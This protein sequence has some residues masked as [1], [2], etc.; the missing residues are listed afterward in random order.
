MR[1]LVGV[2]PYM[3]A[4]CL[5][6]KRHRLLQHCQFGTASVAGQARYLRSLT[7]VALQGAC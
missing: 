6:V 1:H 2:Q 7:A 5:D 3:P 4:E